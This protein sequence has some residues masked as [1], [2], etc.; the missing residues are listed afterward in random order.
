MFG[1]LS[2]VNAQYCAE[3]RRERL[4]EPSNPRRMLGLRRRKI[5]TPTTIVS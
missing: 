2:K 1:I 5:T 3:H 4:S